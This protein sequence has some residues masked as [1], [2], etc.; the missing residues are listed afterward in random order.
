[1]NSHRSYVCMY[2]LIAI[3]NT[4]VYDYSTLQITYVASIDKHT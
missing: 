4:Y 1:M 3:M 2:N